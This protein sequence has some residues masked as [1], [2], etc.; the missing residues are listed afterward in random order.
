MFKDSGFFRLKENIMRT[1]SISAVNTKVNP[2]KT[3]VE[4]ASFVFDPVLREARKFVQEKPVVATGGGLTFF[5]FLASFF[6]KD[7][8]KYFPLV[9]IP[10]IGA[11]IHEIFVNS[12]QALFN[13]DN[14]DETIGLNKPRF[15]LQEKRELATY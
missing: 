11:F 4:Q 12:K 7:G 9:G 3:L 13:Q 2:R 1:T 14:V 15:L 5:G 8:I 6:I 10:V